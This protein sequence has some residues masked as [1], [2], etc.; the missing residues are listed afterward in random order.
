MND[1]DKERLSQIGAI[2]DSIGI[3]TVELAE[4]LKEHVVGCP[5]GRGC[6]DKLL[7]EDDK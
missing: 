2:M 7:S 3:T 6:I 5:G 4:K 1:T